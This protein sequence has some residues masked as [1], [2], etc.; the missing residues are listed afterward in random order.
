MIWRVVLSVQT[1]SSI[2]FGKNQVEG[3]GEITGQI[4]HSTKVVGDNTDHRLN[5]VPE[6]NLCF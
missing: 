4:C 5:L 6:N 3:D 1:S 2:A